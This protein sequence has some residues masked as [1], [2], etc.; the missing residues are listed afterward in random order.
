MLIHF[1]AENHLSIRD[2]QEL[3]LAAS[4]LKDVET[5]IIACDAAPNGQILP[6]AVIYGANASGKSN[7]VAAFSFVCQAVLSSHNRGEPGGEVPR[8][9][10]ALDPKFSKRP[11]TF[12]VD[13]VVEGTRYHYGFQCSDKEFTEEWLLAFPSGRRRMLFE[14][15]GAEFNF[16]RGLRGRNKIIADLTRPNSLFLSA[17]AQNDHE[18][19]TSIADFFRSI[20]FDLTIDVPGVMASV[21][22]KEGEIDKRVIEFLKRVGAG[23]VDYRRHEE[24]I[25]EE[26]QKFNRAIVSAVR[27]VVEDKD[28]DKELWD[29]ISEIE[30]D[31]K[32]VNIQ[33]AHIGVDGMPIYFDLDRE[34]AGTRRLL[35]L[36]SEVFGALDDGTLLVVD[37]LDA[38]LHT[39]ACEA[40]LSLFSSPS[41]NPKGAQLIAT[42]H[43]TNLLSSSTL[44]RDQVWFTEQDADGATVVY[45]LSDIRSRK[46]DNIEKGYL[47]GRYGAIPFVGSAADFYKL[48]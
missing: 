17:A 32:R 42:T 44:R 1:S 2:R 20:K 13:F 16:G 39:L 43:D 48:A 38:S 36:L 28:K 35:I 18:L 31:G 10:F 7:V 29:Q 14:R 5:G 27:S 41:T 4:A 15:D 25:P 26:F 3:S 45:P 11:S 46:G 22:L 9:P 23:I 12:D 34:S 21:H 33:L 19:L 30:K 6:T 24:K 47:Q 8:V 40:V 37:E